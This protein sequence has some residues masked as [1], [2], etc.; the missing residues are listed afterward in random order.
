M[1]RAV[2]DSVGKAIVA[3]VVAVRWQTAK[4]K[5]RL[6]WSTIGGRQCYIGARKSNG[7]V[8]PT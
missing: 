1:W 7:I 8:G 5:L 2:S 4:E 6:A 3:A